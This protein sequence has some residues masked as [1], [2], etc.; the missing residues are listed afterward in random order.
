LL[1]YDN[2]FSAP[3]TDIT[4]SSTTD[5]ISWSQNLTPAITPVYGSGALHVNSSLADGTTATAILNAIDFQG[6]LSPSLEFW[7]A[8]DNNNP[9]DSD[10]VV[11]KISTN[12][13]NT[14]TN[15]DLI[16]RYNPS[17]TTPGWQHYTIDL[18]DYVNDACVVIA[19]EAN[20]AGGGDMWMDRLL[21]S[22]EKDMEIALFVPQL[23]DLVACN[24]DQKE[25]KV[26]IT[27]QSVMAVDFDE[28]LSL[29]TL[30]VTGSVTKILC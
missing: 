14:F 19:F 25:L 3:I 2:D 13:G 23:D 9:I 26:S 17:F 18:S 5:S 24:L 4:F 22:A 30:E 8:H 6:C 20:S 7:F 28:T 21:I 12:G 29:L 1:P 10:H 16:Y 15:K 11:V 27:N